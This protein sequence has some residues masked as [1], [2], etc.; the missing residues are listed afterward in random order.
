M[1][2]STHK[3]LF[4]WLCNITGNQTNCGSY[5]VF[6]FTR[7]LYPLIEEVAALPYFFVHAD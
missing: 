4:N 3:R 7:A 6:Q 5:L 2:S 1:F